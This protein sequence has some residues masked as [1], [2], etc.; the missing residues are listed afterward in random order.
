MSS[1]SVKDNIVGSPQSSCGEARF[2]IAV[3]GCGPK[4]LFCLERL[5]EK[6]ASVANRR[7]LEIVIFEQAPYPG[8]G[9]VYDPRQPDYLRMNFASHN[10]SAWP[11]NGHLNSFPQPTLVD[12]LQQYFPHMAKPDAFIPRA[13][14]GE[15]LHWCF[16]EVF[17]QLK[18]TADVRIERASVSQITRVG[19][20]WRVDSPHDSTVYDEVLLTVG[21]EGW[22]TSLPQKLA[23]HPADVNS[24]FPTEKQL[25]VDH[26]CPQ[27]TV[28]I[29]GFGLTVID[30]ILAMTEGRGGHLKRRD[31][32]WFYTPSGQEPST[33]IPCSRSGR[34]MFAKP[35]PGKALVP[36]KVQIIW[37]RYREVLLQ[38]PAQTDGLDFERDMWPVIQDAAEYAVNLCGGRGARQWFDS[39]YMVDCDGQ[40]AAELMRQS[41]RVAMGQQNPSAAWAWGEAWRQLYPALVARI[42]HGGLKD[43]SWADFRPLAAEMERLAFGPPAEN[44]GRLLALMEHQIVDLRFVSGCYPGTESRSIE[45]E[46]GTTQ[47]AVDH[48]VNA[49]LPA[50]SELAPEGLLAG[51]VQDGLVCRHEPSQ[52][53]L[54]NRETRPLDSAGHPIAGLALFGRCTEG[55]ILGNDTLSRTMHDHPETWANSVCRHLLCSKGNTHE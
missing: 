46:S 55:C 35:V 19:Q 4:G 48:F 15:Y 51:L 30:A 16:Q 53:L 24:V 18:R 29:R 36:E 52:A 26:V 45:T 33:I 40:T 22:R 25:S 50:P 13:L 37:P 31:G 27:S 11:P 39:W 34:P 8:A 5:L 54:V 10:I 6:L 3:I 20:S 38:L 21:H 2:R 49:V 9:Q 12:W 17:E 1:A 44:L 41:Y 32:K 42:S 47:L 28:V 7:G 43:K 23:G 14:V